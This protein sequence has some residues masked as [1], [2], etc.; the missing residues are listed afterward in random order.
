MRVLIDSCSQPTVISDRVVA[1]YGLPKE[2][3]SRGS[4]IEGATPGTV[5]T[6]ELIRLCLISRTKQFSIEVKA[7]VVPK[8]SMSYRINTSIDKKELRELSKLQ[9]ADPVLTKSIVFIEDHPIC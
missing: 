3:M 2:K 5:S 9:L 6:G 8:N 1:R 4:I 7:E